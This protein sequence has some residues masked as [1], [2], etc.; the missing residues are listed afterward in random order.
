MGLV[1]LILSIFSLVLSFTSI[2]MVAFFPSLIGIILG[3]IS[4]VKKKAK[5]LS[6]IGVILNSIIVILVS[7]VFIYNLSNNSNNAVATNNDN[8]K[9]PILCM[10]FEDYYRLEEKDDG[11]AIIIVGTVNEISEQFIEDK[12]YYS[13]RIELRILDKDLEPH[14]IRI[15]YNRPYESTKIL[16]EDIIRV[17]GI[18]KYQ[19]SIQAENIEIAE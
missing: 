4:L 12:N 17:S 1:S 9:D 15:A 10:D 5:I 6:I 3:I 11:K 18:Y 19:A 8:R 7:I 14:Y 2:F 13:T 16:K